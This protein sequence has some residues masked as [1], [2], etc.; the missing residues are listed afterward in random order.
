VFWA[1]GDQALASGVNFVLTLV[2]ARQVTLVDFSA[3]GLAVTLL[4]FV[5]A[6]HRAYLTQPMAIDAVSASDGQVGRQLKEVLL[7]QVF[8][9]PL[10]LGMFGAVG[11]R[12]FPAG[13]LVF[14][15]SVFAAAFLAQ[16]TLRRV[17]FAMGR[18]QSTFWLDGVAYGGQLICVWMV[19]RQWQGNAPVAVLMSVAAVPF[20]VSA[21][22]AYRH[23]PAD[24]RAA[25]WPDRAGAWRAAAA[26]WQVSKWV[27]F[28]QVFMFGSFM[29][30][31]FQIAEWGKPLWVAQYNATASILNGLNV[32]RQALGNHL[33]IQ[34]AQRL[35]VGGI[36]ALRSYLL[37]SAAWIFALSVLVVA[38]LI[39]LGPWMV[40]VL[41]GHRFEDAVP[42]LPHA[43]VGQLVSMLTLVSQAGGLVIHRTEQIFWA[44][45]LGTVLSFGLAPLLIPSW[46]LLGAVWVSN[47]GVLVP[48]IWHALAFRRDM[49]RFEARALA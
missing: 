45:V 21:V 28:S 17:L 38:S 3:Y 4:W 26:H 9:W 5:G 46:G 32:M 25:P 44:Y 48:A 43:A 35:R 16:E 8:G 39:A 18:L 41:F 30:V 23:L 31:P 42:L 10:V 1:L 13:G 12:Y 34:A 24:M 22:L 14:A 11:W 47:V 27:C 6:L 36:A 29:L 20:G 19:G 40:S 33:P 2:V 15:A 37:Q 49:Q 7:L